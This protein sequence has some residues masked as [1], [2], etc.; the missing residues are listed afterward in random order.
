MIHTNALLSIIYSITSNVR[1]FV[2]RPIKQLQQSWS[3]LE[4]NIDDFLTERQSEMDKTW[5]SIEKRI[6]P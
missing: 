6:K 1:E 3:N 5:N 4:N 2:S